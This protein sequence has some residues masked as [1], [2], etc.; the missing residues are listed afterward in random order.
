[1]EELELV[2]KLKNGDEEAFRYVLETYHRMVL[3]CSFKF[4]RNRE[5]AEDLAQDVFMEV[6][7]S[8][9]S[10][11]MNSKL[12]TWIYRIT[13]TKSINHLKSIKRKKRFAFIVSVFGDDD[14]PEK[15]SSSENMNPDK[16]LENKDK[17]AVLK[18]AIEKLPENQQIAFTLS[19]HKE[20]SYEE[21]AA[22]LNTTIPSVESL[23]HRA[24]KN[25]RKTL[26]NYYQKQLEE[27]I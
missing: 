13:V 20:M 15:I 9:N 5:S 3:N 25:L 2:R 24:K 26:F 16:L 1:M 8:I 19:K 12:S 21:I 18:W 22:V 10:F 4:L 23:L 14:S 7:E 6:F 11:K 17:A 27:G